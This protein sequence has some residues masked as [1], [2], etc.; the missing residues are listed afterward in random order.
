MV[1]VT[2]TMTSEMLTN[3]LRELTFIAPLL[4]DKGL[5]LTAILGE[6]VVSL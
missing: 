1:D 4:E 3:K 5:L 6:Q 2:A